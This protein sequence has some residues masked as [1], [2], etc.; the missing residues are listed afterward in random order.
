MAG[1]FA[2]VGWGQNPPYIASFWILVFSANIWRATWGRTLFGLGPAPWV[3]TFLVAAAPRGVGR[4]FAGQARIE[5][6]LDVLDIELDD[7][8]ELLCISC[9]NELKSDWALDRLPD[10]K[11]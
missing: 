9:C 7:P 1:I 10:C 6:P 3:P 5:I 8:S 2:P 11:S 4:C